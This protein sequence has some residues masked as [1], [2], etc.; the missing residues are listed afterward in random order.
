MVLVGHLPAEY[1][2][3]AAVVM[4]ATWQMINDSWDHAAGDVVPSH[5][6]EVIRSRHGGSAHRM[7]TDPAGRPDGARHA[8]MIQPPAAPADPLARAAD[9]C[10]YAVARRADP[11]CSRGGI[12]ARSAEVFLQP[13]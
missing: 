7:P 12:E 4:L 3:V 2:R 10:R 11:P 8:Q 6:V 1:A 5:F 13:R 9:S